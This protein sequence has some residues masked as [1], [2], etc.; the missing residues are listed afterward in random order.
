M[1]GIIGI[2]TGAA[3]VRADPGG[4]TGGTFVDD[5]SEHDGILGVLLEGL[6]RLEY[7]GYDSAG[8]ALVGA[9]DA[10]GLWRARAANGTR[11][12][13]DLVKRA[14]DAPE[15]ATA[16]IGHTR[17]ATHGRPTEVNA[18]PHV[19]CSGRIGLIHNGIIENHVE[20]ADELIAN[21]HHFESE[22][23]TEVLAH[24]V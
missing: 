16:G 17:W 4:T 19:D 2:T 24:L 8:L 23:D 3:A 10:R 9:P 1:C 21:G 11:S 5:V 18:H 14:G 15:G 22:T 12:L 20:L 7:R 13:D 6:A